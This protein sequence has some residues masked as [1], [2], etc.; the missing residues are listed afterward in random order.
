MN[1]ML[2]E[3]NIKPIEWNDNAI[4]N[5]LFEIRF[6][7]EQLIMTENLVNVS[8]SDN[9]IYLT[10]IDT[11]M[12]NK[13]LYDIVNDYPFESI[14]LIECDKCGNVICKQTWIVQLEDIARTTHD[15]N[16]SPQFMVSLQKIKHDVSLC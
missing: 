2:N 13:P 10:F 11:I 1:N 9:Y 3:L 7:P 15:Y 5:S 12:D 14:E 16:P 6:S 8:Q 4:P